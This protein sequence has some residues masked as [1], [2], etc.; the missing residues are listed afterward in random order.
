MRQSRRMSF[1]EAI[2]NVAVG[3]GVAVTT[4]LLVFPVFGLQ[5]SLADNLLIGAVFTVVSV[6]RSYLLRRLFEV[7]RMRGLRM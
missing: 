1:V 2:A 7:V 6:G 4:Q 5:A 3:Y